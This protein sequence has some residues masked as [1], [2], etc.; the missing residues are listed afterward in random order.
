[1]NHLLKRNVI[2]LAVVEVM[3]G[4]VSFGS[5]RFPEEEVSLRPIDSMVMKGSHQ[6]MRKSHA[7]TI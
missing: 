1:M 6:L 4:K 5:H 3:P 2:W 7:A